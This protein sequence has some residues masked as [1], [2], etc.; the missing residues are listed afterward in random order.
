MVVV[1]SDISVSVSFIE[2]GKFS[3]G[4]VSF[5]MKK[6]DAVT[7]TTLGDSGQPEN[8]PHTVSL[9]EYFIGE[10]EVT[11]E[12]WEEV[13]GS[14]PSNFS[15]NP[16]SGEVQEKRPV[17]RVSWYDSIAFCN[18]LTK[19]VYGDN[20]V[21]CVYYSNSEF[22][23]VYE[24][25]EDVYM[26][27]SK[28]GFRL[29]TEAEWEYAARGGEDYT[30]SGSANIDDVAWYSSNSNDKTHQVKKKDPNCYGL[31][32]MSG[33]VGE[34]CFDIYGIPPAS[35]DN[36]VASFGLGRVCRDGGYF[37]SSNN[38]SVVIRNS[39]NNIYKVSD[40]GLRLACRL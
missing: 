12:L 2:K 6:I 19:K 33:N 26:D 16:A 9:S 5:L 28:K 37:Y 30:Y 29:P 31:Y 8:E 23:T 24:S 35:G 36:P 1:N 17:E 22:T 39:Q 40:L 27:M 38:C 14:N 21:E 25:G 34:W 32:D 3:V 4:G 7:G 11:Q 13:M 20:T 10:T 18:K 15:S